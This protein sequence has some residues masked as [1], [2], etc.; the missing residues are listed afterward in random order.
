MTKYL[1]V[2]ALF[3]GVVGS[4]VGAWITDWRAA[5]KAERQR[6]LEQRLRIAAM[7]AWRRQQLMARPKTRKD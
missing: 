5:R 3:G 7:T 4:F 1:L 2:V 6:A